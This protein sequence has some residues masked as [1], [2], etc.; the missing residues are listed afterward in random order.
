MPFAKSS[1]VKLNGCVRNRPRSTRDGRLGNECCKERKRERQRE[2]KTFERGM[3]LLLSEKENFNS[4]LRYG[5][6]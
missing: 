2:G 5:A 3:K 4:R 1:E 6:R